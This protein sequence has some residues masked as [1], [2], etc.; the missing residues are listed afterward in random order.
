VLQANQ[1]SL[2]ALPELLPVLRTGEVLM[3]PHPSLSPAYQKWEKYRQEKPVRLPLFRMVARGDLLWDD[4]V[5]T[6]RVVWPAR[7]DAGWNSQ[8]AGLGLML[9]LDGVNI[10]WAGNPGERVEN[11]LES[12]MSTRQVSILIQGPHSREPGL[13]FSWLKNIKS[14]VI[15]RPRSGF[16]PEHDLSMQKR[17]WIETLPT[18]LMELDHTGPIQIRGGNGAFRVLNWDQITKEFTDGK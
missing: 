10:L 2:G 9:D 18:E 15:V 1:R 11:R 14:Q 12:E 4:P 6:A 17:Q 7:Q 3:P 16:Y 5:S 13:S 8:N